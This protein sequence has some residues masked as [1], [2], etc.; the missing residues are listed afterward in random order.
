MVLL[1]LTGS[2]SAGKQT[3]ADFLS[4]NRGFKQMNLLPPGLEVADEAR[5]TLARLMQDWKQN[6]VI[7][8]FQHPEQV[9]IFK[10]RTFFA[11]LAVDAPLQKR[12]EMHCTKHGS[13]PLEDFVAMDDRSKYEEALQD[14]VSQASS[15]LLNSGSLAELYTQLERLDLTNLQH[16]RPS[17]DEYFMALALEASSRSNCLLRKSGSIVEMEHIVAGTGYTGTPF[18]VPNCYEPDGCAACHRNLESSAECLCLHSE[19]GALLNLTSRPVLG[20]TLYCTDMPCLQCMKCIVQV[21]IKR[22][23]YLRDQSSSGARDLAAQAGVEVV[24][25]AAL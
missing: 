21:R 5:Q 14:C 12:W 23:V 3:V 1:G 20:A 11:L 24:S 8:G 19:L 25:M 15:T 13:L 2:L 17:W 7:L 10:R 4:Q 16:T 18:D 6:W 9:R 22:I